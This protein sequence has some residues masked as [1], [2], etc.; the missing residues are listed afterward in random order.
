MPKKSYNIVEMQ[1][2]LFHYGKTVIEGELLKTPWLAC[3]PLAYDG[4]RIKIGS[5]GEM[6]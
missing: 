4:F 6:P 2:S 1:L 5:I 3:A